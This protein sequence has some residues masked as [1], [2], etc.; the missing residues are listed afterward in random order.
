MRH[1][2]DPT[3]PRPC[4]V[5]TSSME[6]RDKGRHCRA[7]DTLVLDSGLH[8][9]AEFL[10]L[11]RRGGKVCA[12]L[13]PDGTGRVR[14]ADSPL[15][16]R[17]S[18]VALSA[19]MAACGDDRGGEPERVVEVTNEPED[20]PDLGMVRA[21]TTPSPPPAGSLG[22][23]PDPGL[24]EPSS[25]VAPGASAGVAADPADRSHGTPPAGAPPPDDDTAGRGRAP[26]PR[27]A[28]SGADDELVGLVG[29]DDL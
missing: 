14:F 18:V 21:A 25:R 4:P 5:K 26:T 1:P 13:R 2:D 9:R 24:V 10:D 17:L 27:P 6:P 16:R 7:C 29:L 19:A 8:T 20:N 11:V 23:P 28:G 15:K 12:H 3:V 22:P